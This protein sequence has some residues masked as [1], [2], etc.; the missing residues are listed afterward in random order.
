MEISKAIATGIIYI[1]QGVAF[2]IAVA[3]LFSPVYIITWIFER[4]EK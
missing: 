1:A 2:G 4:G 3:G